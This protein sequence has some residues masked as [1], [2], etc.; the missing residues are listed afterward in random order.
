MYTRVHT[1]KFQNKL[2]K[3][4]I[5]LSMKQISDPMFDKGLQMRFFVDVNDTTLNVINVWDNEQNSAVVHQNHNDFMK[6]M[7]EM[8]VNMLIT[9]GKT[10]ATYSNKTIFSNF[11]K[12]D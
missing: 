3:N 4:S 9:G 2:A 8:G 5:K 10:E 6:E 7:K 1:F 12:L 11:T